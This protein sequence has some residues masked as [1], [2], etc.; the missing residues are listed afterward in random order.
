MQ[1]ADKGAVELNLCGA[2]GAFVNR[3]WTV[4]HACRADLTAEHAMLNNTPEQEVPELLEHPEPQVVAAAIS[5]EAGQDAPDDLSFQAS[6]PTVGW[7]DSSD[8]VNQNIAASEADSTE[9]WE[10][11]SPEI[12]DSA[13]QDVAESIDAEDVEAESIDLAGRLNFPSF[14]STFDPSSLVHDDSPAQ[15]GPAEAEY[16]TSLIA[17]ADET[18]DF[19]SH[20]NDVIEPQIGEANQFSLDTNASEVLGAAADTDAGVLD[21]DEGPNF[22]SLTFASN[23]DHS[24][25][26][27]ESTL[28]NLQGGSPSLDSA[29]VHESSEE[30]VAQDKQSDSDP[31]E[32]AFGILN[33]TG[34]DYSS[35]E[36]MI[37]GPPEK[38]ETILDKIKDRFDAST[39]RNAGRFAAIG[40]GGLVFICVLALIATTMFKEPQLEN[41]GEAANQTTGGTNAESW[42]DYTDPEGLY[43]ASLPGNPVARKE[44]AATTVRAD[45]P[46][47]NIY[48]E[49]YIR[50]IPAN[51]NKALDAQLLSNQLTAT[52]RDRGASAASQSQEVN[53]GVR[54]L[55]GHFASADET[56]NGDAVYFI[57]G[58]ILYGMWLVGANPN[59]EPELFARLV[60]G[61][62]PTR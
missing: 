41:S 16:S 26:S 28:A 20:A 43:V 29:A 3:D 8:Y 46:E 15:E 30:P 32:S 13:T 11:A 40:A 51:R 53:D 52:A 9:E 47:R 61:F 62:R 4:C 14:Q 18:T 25:N 31:F 23:T 37:I 10:Q 33:S 12:A 7:D 21:A 36:S 50:R 44:P 34:P 54:R 5:A 45:I 59:G 60:D 2:C 58:D 17:N 22:T 35:V 1:N 49:T 56:V 55:N 48:V 19:G 57:K 42:S 38:K 6:G 39:L 24:S 27:F